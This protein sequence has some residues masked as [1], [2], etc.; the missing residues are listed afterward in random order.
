MKQDGAFIQGFNCQCF[1]DGKYQVIVAEA[2][3]NQAPDQEHL[4]AMLDQVR[5]NLDRLP[6]RLIADA[7]YMSADN[8]DFCDKLEV[9]AYISVSREKHGQRKDGR[10]ELIADEKPAW[11]M[12]RAKLQTPEGK[13][14]YSRRKAIVEPVFGQIKDARAFRRFSVRGLAKVRTE[15]TLICLCS[16]LL[17][18]LRLVPNQIADLAAAKR[19]I[20]APVPG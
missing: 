18:L 11:T 14:I 17:K 1:V 7:G 9:D 13:H 15:W 4:P 16:N 20:S 5:Q 10:D 12:M 8:V 6:Q 3:T 19:R 2:V